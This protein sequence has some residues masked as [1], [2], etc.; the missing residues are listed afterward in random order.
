MSSVTSVPGGPATGPTQA[1]GLPAPTSAARPLGSAVP[2]DGVLGDG[3]P[4]P[5]R[6][7][8][9]GG[10]PG[11]LRIF[12][13]VVALICLLGGIAGG[14]AAGSSSDAITRARMHT[15]QIVRVQAIAADLLKADLSATNVFLTA[16]EEEPAQRAAYDQALMNVTGRITQAGA[17]QPADAEA[18]SRLSGQV[19]LY[20]E[21][22]EHAR[23]DN[24][25]GLT[26]GQRYQQLASTA[27]RSDALPLATAVVEANSARLG[28]SSGAGEIG[29]PA[30]QASIQTAAML[31]AVLALAGLSWWLAR[32]TR[33]RLNPALLA[34]AALVLASGLLGVGVQLHTVSRMDDF[35]NGVMRR[36]MIS[37]DAR[38][39]VYDARAAENLALIARRSGTGDEEAFARATEQ[40][41]QAQRE[42]GASTAELDRYVARHAEITAADVDRGEW[43]AAVALAVAPEGFVELETQLSEQSAVEAAAATESLRS[44]GLL[45]ALRWLL[46]LAGVMAAMLVW[47]GVGQPA[48]EFRSAQHD[49][50]GRHA[51]RLDPPASEPDGGR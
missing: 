16:G 24:A 21:L 49:R 12:G 46:P 40:V 22:V 9:L 6:L 36:A 1:S 13:G 39:R 4:L 35:A 47:R 29:W 38:T 51:G 5:D 14:I 50:G 48:A 37:A 28:A 20:A 10:T 42:L 32:R 30:V 26:V 45:P 43:Q 23:A 3:V 18:M 8:W 17:A 15:E 34:A 7:D 31:V 44:A 25:Q 11:R 19:V 2:L 27:L 33:R 41:R